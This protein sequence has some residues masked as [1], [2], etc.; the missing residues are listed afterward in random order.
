VP[1]PPKN[2]AVREAADWA[3]VAIGQ[4]LVYALI[5]LHLGA[6]LWHVAARRDGV[7]DRML[8]A[9]RQATER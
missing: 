5:L 7:L 2:P 9:Q 6:T 3:H 8:P 4:W 1:A